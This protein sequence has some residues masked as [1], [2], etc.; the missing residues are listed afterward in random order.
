MPAVRIE[1]D[2]TRPLA[3]E[4]GSGHNRWH[5]GL[6]P[7][8]TVRP[9]DELTLETRDG[10]D[11]QLGPGR[12]HA[13]VARIDRGLGHPLTGPIAVEGAEP[14]DVLEVEL[15]AFETASSGITCVIPGF[16]F[17]AEDFPDPYLV[18]W[19]IEDG[20]ARSASLPGVAVPGDPFPGVLG[21]A[22]SP[23]RLEEQRRREEAV[24]EAGGPVADPAPESAVPA[25]CADGLRTIPPRETGGNLDV[26]QLV[27]GSRVLLPVD[28]PGALFSIGDLH[29]AQ[30][31]GEVCG[32]GIEIAGAVTIRFGLRAA[33]AWRPRSPAF[34]TPGRPERRSFVTTGLP[35]TAAGEN[36]AMD[37]ELAARNALH[38]LIGWV[39]E[40]HG[41]EPEAAYCLASAAAD[42]RIAE[43]VDVPNPVVT[44]SLPLDIFES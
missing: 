17:L 37:L 8:A 31:D 10:L 32:T 27:A 16:G 20:K 39:V 44:A 18:V 25:A 24:R 41:F 19:E 23:E 5:P 43:V 6:E 33:P 36:R 42:L 35:V 22:P 21:T 11:G 3:A 9:G 40:T 26:R 15:L 30:G 2:A 29:F 1:V 38:E 13:D 14:G 28:V 34:E 12:T 4:P 7:I